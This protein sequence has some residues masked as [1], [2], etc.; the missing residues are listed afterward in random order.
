MLGNTLQ[1][2]WEIS[3]EQQQANFSRFR[4]KKKE[5][6]KNAMRTA[7]EAVQLTPLSLKIIQLERLVAKFPP[8][9]MTLTHK[10]IKKQNMTEIV[11]DF[12]FNY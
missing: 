8:M 11:S 1:K 7:W 9:K 3:I 4:S 6:M 10:L 12:T 5:R 2:R